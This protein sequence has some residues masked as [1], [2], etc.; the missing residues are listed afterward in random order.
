MSEII[1]GRMGGG[2]M[3][4]GRAVIVN[5]PRKV[6]RATEAGLQFLRTDVAEK[7]VKGFGR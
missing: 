4:G 5:R 2:R 3:G 1:V 6:A 7:R